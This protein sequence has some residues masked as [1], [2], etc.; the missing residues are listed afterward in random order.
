MLPDLSLLEYRLVI[1]GFPAVVVQALGES[2]VPQAFV[3]L[4]AVLLLVLKLQHLLLF[5]LQ[6]IILEHY[7]LPF[8]LLV[9]QAIVRVTVNCRPSL[10]EACGF[11]YADATLFADVLHASAG[12]LF[13]VD[14]L[15]HDLL[16]VALHVHSHLPNDPLDV[17]VVAL[18]E[19]E[20]ETESVGLLPQDIELTQLG[21]EQSLRLGTLGLLLFSGRRNY[22]RLVVGLWV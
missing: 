8:F 14:L 5:V 18:V 6:G 10:P 22:L 7:V 17:L 15:V 12:T 4:Q 13:P 11:D 2:G 9:L 19:V 21:S 1:G 16:C 20:L 3:A